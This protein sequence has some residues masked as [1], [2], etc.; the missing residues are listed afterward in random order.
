[1]TVSG[2][3][4]TRPKRELSISSVIVSSGGTL[5]VAS[6]PTGAV[7]GGSALTGASR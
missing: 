5:V 2:S 7:G 6:E 3:I 1:M 4:S